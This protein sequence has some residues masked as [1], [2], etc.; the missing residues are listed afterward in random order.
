MDA[1]AICA[2][3]DRNRPG[4]YADMALNIARRIPL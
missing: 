3:T 2:F 4:E 1:V